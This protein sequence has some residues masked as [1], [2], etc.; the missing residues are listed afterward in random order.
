MG[1]DVREK[2]TKD[3]PDPLERLFVTDAAKGEVPLP[4]S[5]S[6]RVFIIISLKSQMS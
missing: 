1:K 4:T 3:V 2:K 5:V 6:A